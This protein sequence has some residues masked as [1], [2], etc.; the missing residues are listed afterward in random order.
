MYG[1]HGIEVLVQFFSIA[2]TRKQ[3]FYQLDRFIPVYMKTFA[4]GDKKCFEFDEI[5]CKG[6]RIPLVIYFEGDLT[7]KEWNDID[8]L[9]QLP[10]DDT[11]NFYCTIEV[12][13]EEDIKGSYLTILKRDLKKEFLYL[14]LCQTTP[15]FY[16]VAQLT[17]SIQLHVPSSTNFGHLY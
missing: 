15:T 4:N 14:N 10:V 2:K 8:Q 7:C 6:D 5:R 12:R 3:T 11:L 17:K 1:W 9:V 13:L 16:F